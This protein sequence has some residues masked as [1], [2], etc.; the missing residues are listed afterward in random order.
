MSSSVIISLTYFQEL[1]MNGN[2]IA[3]L[4]QCDKY[5]PLSL[6]T[7][8][9]AKNN[10][11]DLNEICTLSHLNNLNSITISDNPCVLMTGNSM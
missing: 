5:L 3:H 10:I 7:L 8:T 1:Y 2:R 11:S 9:L 6:E 4:R